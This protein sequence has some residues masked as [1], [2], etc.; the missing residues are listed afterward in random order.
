MPNVRFGSSHKGIDL[1]IAFYVRWALGLR[2][3]PTIYLLEVEDMG[4]S[5]DEAGR[6]SFSSRF[7]CRIAFELFVEDYERAS[8]ASTTNRWASR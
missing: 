5:D 3:L 4:Q 6:I 8:L 1:L 7:A 2:N